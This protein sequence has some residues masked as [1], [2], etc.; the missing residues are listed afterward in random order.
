[1]NEHTFTNCRIWAGDRFE[2]GKITVTGARISA[3]GT[4]SGV[5]GKEIPCDGLAV[6]PALIDNHVHFREPGA[7]T[8]EDFRSGSRAAAHGGVCRVFEIQNSPPLL[9]SPERVEKK[10]RL[11]SEKSSVKVELYASAVPQILP[12]LDDMS[13]ITSGLKLFMA[14]SHGDDGL[15]SEEAM[16]PFFQK[17]AEIGMHL[18]VH[19][20]D[21]GVIRR[22]GGPFAD[23][24]AAFFSKA[25]PPRAEIVAVERALRLAGE[26]GTRLHVFHLTTAGAVDLIVEARRNGVDVT[27]ST[28]PHYL[29]FCDEDVARGGSLFKCYPSIKG[30]HDRERL[31][32]ALRNDEV[33]II[34]TDH[35]PHLPEEKSLPFEKVPAGISSVDLLLPLLCTLTNRGLLTYKDLFRLTVSNPIKIHRIPEEAGLSA[36]RVADLVFFDPSA[37]WRVRR[38]DFLSRASCSPYVGMTL[39][40]RVAAT[41]VDGKVAYCDEK[42]PLN[43]LQASC[44]RD[45]YPR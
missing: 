9:T 11:I 8:K 18:I 15:D 27:G 28:C 26:Y 33:Q 14:P 10:K 45:P 34:S 30:A 2:S 6:F 5:T 17:A 29:F 22:E 42:G 36:G 21:G 44:G 40:G 43:A 31:L 37:S 7:E 3:I 35:A 12:V 38:E 13:R 19:A 24:G 20:E 16:R 41:L 25:R 4:F 39:T 32:D 1:M 23:K